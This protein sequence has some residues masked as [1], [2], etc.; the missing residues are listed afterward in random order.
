VG[1]NE[2]SAYQKREGI[3]AKISANLAI[4]GIWFPSGEALEPGLLFH[5]FFKDGVVGDGLPRQDGDKPTGE[6]LGGAAWSESFHDA[7]QNLTATRSTS[8]LP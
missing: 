6:V 5:R 3:A 2:S 4:R 8:V 1:E 7:G